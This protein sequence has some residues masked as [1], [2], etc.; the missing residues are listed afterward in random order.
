MLRLL[1]IFNFRHLRRKRL[2]TFLCLLGIALGVAVMVGI[3]LANQNALQSFR[4]TVEAVTGKAT[5]QILGGPSSIPDSVAA[6][7]LSFPHIQ[8]TP[9]L[10]YVAAVRFR[11]QPGSGAPEA[12]HLLAIDPFTD[13]NFRDYSEAAWDSEENFSTAGAADSTTSRSFLLHPAVLVDEP[14]VT[15]YQLKIGDT[16]EVLIGNTWQKLHL[17]GVIPRQMLSSSGLENLA[18][19]DISTGQEILGRAGYV[20]R[21]DLI[22]ADSVAQILAAQLPPPLRIQ[23]PARRGQRIDDMLRSFRLNL[24]AL[25]FLAVF[26]GMFLIYNTMMFAVLHRR[27]QIGILRC[28]GV[29]PRQVILNTVLEA[30]GLGVVGALLGLGLGMALA[31]YA[32]RTVT[33]TLSEL[34][35]FLKVSNVNSNWG[36]IIKS[37]TLGLLAT[38]VASAVPVIEAAK[39][40]P[41]VAVR[42][43]SLEFARK[44]SHLGSPS[45]GWRF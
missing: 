15:T 13:L 34:Y 23:S 38:L 44:N 42:R 43:S 5:H 7:I 4:R 25:S 6:E 39:T 8:A 35:V 18:L 10:E 22:T 33:A 41:A 36:V 12:L 17:A 40:P 2:E 26:V 19:V 16:L 27:K 31:E 32:T 3:D 29:T 20:D 9:I 30:F 24:V 14:F 45:P 28:I 11:S 37:F 21:I 1:R